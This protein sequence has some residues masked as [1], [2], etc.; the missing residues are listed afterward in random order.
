MSTPPDLRDM[1]CCFAEPP[2]KFICMKTLPCERNSTQHR[3][4][5]TQQA[6]KEHSNRPP[7]HTQRIATTGAPFDGSVVSQHPEKSRGSFVASG[8]TRSIGCNAGATTRTSASTIGMSSGVATFAGTEEDG[9]IGWS[10]SSGS[11]HSM[12]RVLGAGGELIS[13]AFRGCACGEDL[14]FVTA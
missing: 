11:Q 2:P 5:G 9:S 13:G 8:S 12:A 4:G 3:N 7:Q 10:T 1:R 6:S 14:L